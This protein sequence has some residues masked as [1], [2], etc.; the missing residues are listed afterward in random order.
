MY[1]KSFLQQPHFEN[2][3][4]QKVGASRELEEVET[5]ANADEHEVLPEEREVPDHQNGQREQ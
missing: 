1:F 4:V 3:G 2:E 5:G